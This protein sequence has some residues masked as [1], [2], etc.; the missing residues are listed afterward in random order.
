MAPSITAH[1]ADD[2]SLWEEPQ[3]SP[4]GHWDQ[5]IDEI[6]EIESRQN[7]VVLAAPTPVAVL[8]PPAA[9]EGEAPP[10]LPQAQAPAPATQP[11]DV[12]RH[13]PPEELQPRPEAQQCVCEKNG[14]KHV[15]YNPS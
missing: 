1:L 9:A 3:A 5:F 15:R 4:A 10:G 2:A 13:A 8:P 12:D 7:S 6:Q 11:E 14:L